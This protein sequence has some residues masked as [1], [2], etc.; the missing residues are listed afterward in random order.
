MKKDKIALL[1]AIAA[2]GLA[3]CGGGDT[4]SVDS[5]STDE[6]TSVTGESSTNP[7]D[8]N[9]PGD[10]IASLVSSI[11]GTDTAIPDPSEALDEGRTYE[12]T[13]DDASITVTASGDF[14]GYADDAAEAGWIEIIP[15]VDGDPTHLHDEGETLVIELSDYDE[16]NDETVLTIK[17][18]DD[19]Y[20]AWPETVI[21]EALK[22]VATTDSPLTLPAATDFEYIHIQESDGAFELD[23]YGVEN[24]NSYGSI[25]AADSNFYSS[26]FYSNTYVAKDMGYA[27][28]CNDWTLAI[29]AR[30]E[31]VVQPVSALFETDWDDIA[32]TAAA[33]YSRLYQGDATALLPEPSGDWDIAYLEDAIEADENY[34][35]IYFFGYDD[36]G[37]ATSLAD[38]YKNDLSNDDNW[39]YSRD[40]QAYIDKDTMTIAAFVYEDS[41]YGTQVRLKGSDYSAFIQQENEYPLIGMFSGTYSDDNGDSGACILYFSSETEG[42]VRFTPTGGSRQT[43]TFTYVLSGRDVILTADEI[44]GC[45]LFYDSSEDAISGT[46]T[47]SGVTY[48]VDTPRL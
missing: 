34:Y 1:I 27:V 41:S 29:N 45:A 20:T 23:L 12:V 5:S 25:V 32:A 24:A 19:F 7:V 13:S 38:S 37:R 42:W 28:T 48:E 35:G 6:M 3:S 21:E 46:L 11:L 10:E 47:V 40:L 43:T 16:E 8:L 9:W 39:V 36:N 26:Y 15:T 22:D 30:F 2:M 31:I 14:T 44:T 17:A 4:S 18:N 33:N